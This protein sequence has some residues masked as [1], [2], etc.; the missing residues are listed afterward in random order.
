MKT[1]HTAQRFTMPVLLSLFILLLR[2]SPAQDDGDGSGP[3]FHVKLNMSSPNAAL[4]VDLVH[5]PTPEVVVSDVVGKIRVYDS[6]SGEEMKSNNL[7]D[8]SLTGPVV[9]DFL[10]RNMLD[11]AVG[12]GAGEVVI[13]DGRTLDVI[14]R[15]NITQGSPFSLQ[16]TVYTVEGPDNQKYD[17]LIIID[18]SGNIYGVDAHNSQLEKV[19]EYRTGS[20]SQA[21]MVIGNVRDQNQADVVASSSDGYL[22]FINPMTGT[23]RKILVQEATALPH[24]PLLF[25]I[26]NDGFD[27]VFISLDSGELRCFRWRE[28]LTPPLEVQWSSVI[29]YS[30]VAPP[31][32]IQSGE[33]ISSARIVQAST[34]SLQLVDPKDGTIIIS[35]RNIYAGINTQPAVIPRSSSVGSRYPELAFGL[36]K[37]LQ[38][39]TNMSEWVYGKGA[40]ELKAEEKQLNHDLAHTIVSYVSEPNS[41]AMVLGVAPV[42]DGHI[43]AFQTDFIVTEI[44][45]STLT[46]WMTNGGSP[47]HNPRLSRE[48][49]VLE[50]ARRAEMRNQISRWEEE[51]QEAMESSDWDRASIL[52]ANLRNAN[53]YNDEYSSLDLKIKWNKHLIAIILVTLITLVTLGAIG[54]V[55][56]RTVGISSLRK[57]GQQAMASGQFED[58]ERHYSKLVKKAPKNRRFALELAQVYQAQKN[59]S[60]E[61]VE[62]YK[63]AYDAAPEDREIMN[64]YARALLRE[65][66]TDSEAKNVYINALPNFPEPAYLEYG[67]GRCLIQEQDF[68]EAAKHLRSA[69]RGGVAT[70][71]LYQALCE[72]YLKTNNTSAKALPVYQQ[73]FEKRKGEAEFLKAYLS[74][75]I[76]A[77]KM[78]HQVESLCEAILE[79]LPSHAPAYIHLARIHLQKNQISMACDEVRQALD[80]NPSSPE[81][82]A[83]LAECYMLQKRRDEEALQAYRNALKFSPNDKDVLKTVASI[84]YDRDQYD[85]EAIAIYNRSVEENPGDPTTLKAL[86]QSAKLTANHELSIKAIEPL[87]H[88]GQLEKA[89]LEQLANAYIKLDIKEPKAEKVL[90]DSLRSFPDNI[91]YTAA[92]ARI[93]ASQDKD[94]VENLQVYESHLKAYPDDLMIGRQLAKTYI[95]ANRYDQALE[96]A[97]QLLQK[98]PNDEE[99]QRLNALA[100]LY[101]NKL[102]EAV[103]E[104]Q[105]ILDRNPDDEQALVNLAVAYAQKLR[106]DEEALGYYSRALKL[107]PRNDLLHLA[108]GRI[109]A[110]KND[111]AEAV[112]SFKAA[113]DPDEKN[114]EK[115]IANIIALLTEKPELLRIRWFLVELLVSYGHIREGLEQIDF[116]NSNHPGQTRNILTA[117]ET[118]LRK[119]PNNM[120]ALIQ[121]GSI[122]LSTDQVKEAV[123]TLE[124]VYGLYPNAAE[125]QEK[126]A[127]CYQKLL[128]KNNDLEARFKLG[129]LFYSQQ[130]YDE[131]IGCF[132]QTSQDYRWEAESTK[133]LG[134]CFS[135]KGMLDLALQE[136]KKLVVDEETKELLYDLAQR[137]EAKKDLV[138]AKTVYRQLFAAD[139]SYKDVKTRFE[140]LSGSTSDPMAFEKTSIVQQMSEEAARRYELLDELGRGAMGIV[141]R[142]R[143]KELEEVVALKILPDNM[144][145]NPEAVRRFKIEARNARKLSHPNIVRIH[146]IG[147][148]MGRKYISMEYVDGT[149]LKR[150]IKST[151]N[152]KIKLSDVVKFCLEIS[153]ALGYAHRLGIVHRDIKPANIMLN[154]N[155]DVKVTDFGIAKMMDQSNLGG[156]GTMIGAVIGTPLYMSPEQVQGVPVDNRADLYSFGVMIYELC[157]GKPPFTEGDLAYQHIH[158]EP[159]KIEGIPDELW[160]IIA[161]CLAKKKEDRY[162]KAELIYDDLKEVQKKIPE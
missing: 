52:A 133:M 37:T 85:E 72:V 24:S 151:T 70:E 17:R 86:A 124:R 19:W 77:K 74:S 65:P 69:L 38:I 150:K 56:F 107:Q 100:S 8:T 157:N 120:A 122:L 105:R 89:H 131:A 68:E 41:G 20:K 144:S 103:S 50:K 160:E 112:N 102:D 162:E 3:L 5:T 61:T 4:V 136:F 159:T 154:S 128:E 97:Q 7:G 134:K 53:P 11:L 111:T 6:I 66:K 27:E 88:A 34:A 139:I 42:S 152:G 30:P 158:Q 25:D 64:S 114:Q 148:E 90:R 13:L 14:Y 143:D 2:I 49:A 44:D 117:L 138:G 12:T 101:G 76:D 113:I 146:D 110:F 140:M 21:P 81:A 32:L 23:G 104:Y 93:L 130:E 79:V 15:L 22:F 118:I 145:N 51:I 95:K 62:I 106:T 10:G 92:L 87:L 137:Y 98:E 141:Y 60:E 73:Q 116:I 31:I 149:D 36:K 63:K 46:P 94:D 142:A 91:E 28:E 75:C 55:I 109:H 67:I 9:G 96:T 153:D 125:I 35:E 71:P 135:G 108:M 16:P 40:Q 99:L 84:Y 126:L 127:K 45:W 156:E 59:Y 18:Q 80:V 161:K 48:W 54:F 39:T 1:P 119:D 47:Y 58:A 83:L 132:Q 129:K 78:D 155:D 147:E 121:K 82:T 43:Y 115:V 123:Q 33:D 26:H 29:P 57:K